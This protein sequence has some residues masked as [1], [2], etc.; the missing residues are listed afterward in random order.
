MTAAEIPPGPDRPMRRSLVFS[1][2]AAGSAG[3]LFLL[4]LLAAH[5]LTLDDYGGFN[6]AL[7]FAMIGESLMDI[8]IH[9]I[10]VRAIARDRREAPAL[11]H[12]SLA[13]KALSGA[14]MFVVMGGLAFSVRPEPEV[15][16]ACLLMLASA[17][18]RSYLLTTR[19]VFMGLER[20]GHD[21]LVVV[22]DRVLLLAAGAVALSQGS[23]LVGLAVVFVVA[24]VFT[25]TGALAL[26][27]RLVGGLSL[28]FD[29]A[30]WR[31]LQ[32]RA[33]PVGM[34]LIV[35]NFYSYID[36]VMLGRLST[37]REVGLYTAAFTIYEGLSYAPAI[38]SSVLTPRLSRL[39]QAD[40]AAHRRLAIRGLLSAAGL[41]IVVAI[42]VWLAAGPILHIYDLYKPS[43]E[44]Q[45]AEAV[46]ALRILVSG[47]VFIFVIWILQ[48][49]ALSVF[50]ERMLLSTTAVGALLN[51][52]LNLFLIPTYGRNGAALATLV[53]EA[54]TMGL[55]LARL[56][57]VLTARLA[58]G[59]DTGSTLPPPAD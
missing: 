39:W 28:R 55:L 11:L 20:F 30:V 31:D 25:V 41:A 58:I 24:R 8:G 38:L 47:L 40:P 26:A 13:L 59:G 42:P 37:L 3:L 48:A 34:F 49:L 14:A 57:G 33:L 10:T 6:L 54:V 16:L 51:V 18:L 21:C 52:V 7:R 29:L 53:G 44:A 46:T 50:R 22:A 1:T 4:Q 2:I 12:N 23:G 5:F 9:Q 35:L 27:R 15:R 43:D 45:F 19:G 32:Q 17:V 56:R 36:T